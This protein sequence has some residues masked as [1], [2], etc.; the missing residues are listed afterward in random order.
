MSYFFLTFLGVQLQSNVYG[1]G[2]PLRW[3]WFSDTIGRPMKPTNISVHSCNDKFI[4]K[5]GAHQFIMGLERWEKLLTFLR[6]S[7]VEV[8]NMTY[9]S[10]TT[11]SK[12]K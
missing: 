3:F 10:Y 12:S 7:S 5:Q 11:E 2:L 6:I 4:L 8:Y 9:M 1:Q